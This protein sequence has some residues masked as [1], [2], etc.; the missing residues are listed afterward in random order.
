LETIL[1]PQVFGNVDVIACYSFWQGG[2]FIKNDNTPVAPDVVKAMR[3]CVITGSKLTQPI[4][5]MMGAE[6]L[7]YTGESS[8]QAGLLLSGLILFCLF[9]FTYFVSGLIPYGM[10]GYSLESST[11]ECCLVDFVY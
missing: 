3:T 2:D 11:S 7:R 10:Y 6:K 5:R 8:V 9:V 4:S 1:G